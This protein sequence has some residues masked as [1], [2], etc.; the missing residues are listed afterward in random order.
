MLFAYRLA[1]QTGNVDV[2]AMLDGMSADQFVG[3]LAYTTIEPFG[4]E[5]DDL[6]SAIIASTVA[7]SQRAK[8]KA[9][10]VDDFMPVF[11]KPEKDWRE[12]KSIFK[13]FAEQHNKSLEKI[14]G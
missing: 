8:G 11:N 5:R 14:N 2:N 10:T 6:R 1:I 4:E 12:I 3:W 7:N 13:T 9:F